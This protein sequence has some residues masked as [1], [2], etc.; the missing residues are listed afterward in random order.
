MLIILSILERDNRRITVQGHPGQKLVRNYLT[1]KLNMI[2]HICHL[3][4]SEGINRSIMVLSR[5][6]QAKV[7]TLLEK[8]IEAKRVQG[9]AQVAEHLPSKP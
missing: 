7:K 3:S 2:V 5:A 8:L 1:N 4:Y 6:V 9:M